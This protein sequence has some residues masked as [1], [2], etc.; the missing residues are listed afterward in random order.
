MPHEKDLVFPLGKSRHLVRSTDFSGLVVQWYLR[1]KNSS[2]AIS[3]HQAELL[4]AE[5]YPPA[6][7]PECRSGSHTSG[8]IVIQ[9]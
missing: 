6:P 4:L 5:A 2:Q 8:I 7:E 1:H 9:N 3:T